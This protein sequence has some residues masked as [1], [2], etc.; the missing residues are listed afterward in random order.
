MSGKYRT[1]VS[2]STQLKRNVGFAD[3]KG[4]YAHERDLEAVLDLGNNRVGC[5]E[6][7]QLPSPGERQ[8]Y[9]CNRIHAKQSNRS[10]TE[11]HDPLLAI[12]GLTMRTINM[13]ISKQRRANTML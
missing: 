7:E 8:W 12:P 9:L 6:M 1:I 3:K 2:A 5:E 10:G 11:Q 4:W 13:A